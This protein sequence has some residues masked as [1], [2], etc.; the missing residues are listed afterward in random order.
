MATSRAAPLTSFD[1]DAIPDEVL[2]V[3]FARLPPRS[4]GVLRTVC[5]RWLALCNGLDIYRLRARQRLTTP[6]LITIAPVHDQG[7][8]AGLQITSYAMDAPFRHQTPLAILPGPTRLQFS[9]AVSPDSRFIYIVGGRSHILPRPPGPMTVDARTDAYDVVTGE[10]RSV[11]P[12]REARYAFAM[13]AFV[14]PLDA[15]PKLIVAGGY[16]AQGCGLASA[17]IYDIASDRWH[18]LPRMERLSG[19]CKGKFADGIFYVKMANNGPLALEAFDPV[20]L[21]WSS[22]LAILAHGRH[23]RLPSPSIEGDDA[24]PEAFAI[25]RFA[26]QSKIE[27]LGAELKSRTEEKTKS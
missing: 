13:A 24:D 8:C 26:G 27:V 17:E 5:K 4:V 7:R 3:C 25:S 10:C 22:P 20:L 11:C 16:D 19:A 18:C 21:R 9:A 2:Q 6:L 1:I 15:R 12:M 23:I 14:H